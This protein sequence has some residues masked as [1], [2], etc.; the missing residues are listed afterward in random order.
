[1]PAPGSSRTRAPGN[2]RWMR[3]QAAP[4]SVA[5]IETFVMRRRARRP[6]SKIV[7]TTL[8]NRVATIASG[9][10]P[11]PQA[12][13]MPIIT[14]ITAASRVSLMPDRKRMKPPSP[15]RPKARAALFPMTTT[16]SA[17]AMAISVCACAVSREGGRVLGSKRRHSR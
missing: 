11:T 8:A 16:I 1:M 14:N 17:P 7:S 3:S 2:A 4:G 9:T 10:A 6:A 13:P 12:M 5:L 15:T